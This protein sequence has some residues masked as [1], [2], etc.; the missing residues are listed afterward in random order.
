MDKLSCNSLEK[1]ISLIKILSTLTPQVMA[2][3]FNNLLDALSDFLTPF[4]DV[5]KDTGTEDVT[6]SGLSTFHESS[7]H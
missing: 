4:N 5:L 2:T 3:S 7:T 6:E 1:L